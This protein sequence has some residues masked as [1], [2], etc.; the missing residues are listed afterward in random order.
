M[1]FRAFRGNSFN[2][3]HENQLFN[4]LYDMLSADWEE[5]NEQLSCS[6]TSSSLVKSLMR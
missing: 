4:A 3:S 6:V 5:R 2:H 1:G